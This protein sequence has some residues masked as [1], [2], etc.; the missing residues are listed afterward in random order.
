MDAAGKA[1]G[2]N[3]D[4]RNE[5]DDAAETKEKGGATYIDPKMRKVRT[6]IQMR[7]EKM[8]A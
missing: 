1:D 3:P 8:R 2:S 4:N 7:F 6:A 5:G